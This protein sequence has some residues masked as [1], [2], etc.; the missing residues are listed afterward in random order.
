MRF[1]FEN[2]KSAYYISLS[3]FK[4][5]FLT[6]CVFFFDSDKN[7]YCLIKIPSIYVLLS[8]YIRDNGKLLQ[9]KVYTS[10]LYV[11]MKR[12][13]IHS[14]KPFSQCEIV[15]NSSN[16]HQVNPPSND[17]RW[18]ERANNRKHQNGTEILKEV[19]LVWE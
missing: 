6:T 5:K 17:H 13:Y 4:S 1:E 19:S 9:T 18:Y 16:S 2:N 12:T 7:T 10:T 3:T 15:R 11:V 14:N 8:N